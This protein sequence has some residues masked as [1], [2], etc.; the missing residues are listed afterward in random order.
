MTE[1]FN[2][3]SSDDEELVDFLKNYCPSTPSQCSN[4]EERLFQEIRQEKRSHHQ[5]K[6]ALFWVIPTGLITG[7]LIFWGTSTSQK[8]TPQLAQEVTELEDF[9][10]E[11]W[12]YSAMDQNQEANPDSEYVTFGN[13]F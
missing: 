6:S 13:E 3:H 12:S 11:V 9:I 5:K 1:F 2:N 4:H 7:L 10:F 8:F